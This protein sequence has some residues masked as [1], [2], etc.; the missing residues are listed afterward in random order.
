M[1]LI[2]RITDY[3]KNGTIIGGIDRYRI[4]KEVAEFLGMAPFEVYNIGRSYYD[5]PILS[6]IYADKSILCRYAYIS[7]TPLKRFEPLYE[8]IKGGK[9]LDYGSGI[10]IYFDPIRYDDRYQKTFS[11][12]SRSGL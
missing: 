6:D 12:S 11:R 10:G 2:S 3:L 8:H 1:I 9:V 7:I 4:L 5:R